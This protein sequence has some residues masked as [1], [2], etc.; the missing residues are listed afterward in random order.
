MTQKQYDKE[1]KVNAVKLYL[2]NKDSKSIRNIANDL[3]VSHASLGHWIMDYRN[4][5]NGCFVGSGNVSD[6]ELKELRR[7]LHIVRQERDILK[8]ALAIF[9]TPQNKGTSL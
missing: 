8:K 5:G 7:E 4:K 1:F 3:G 6:Q 2:A 9:S